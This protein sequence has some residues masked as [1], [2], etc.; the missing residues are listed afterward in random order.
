MT[1]KL[2][3]PTCGKRDAKY[4]S[5]SD[6][7]ALNDFPDTIPMSFKVSKPGGNDIGEL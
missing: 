4:R 1:K 7:T 2:K 3:R 5:S 6:L